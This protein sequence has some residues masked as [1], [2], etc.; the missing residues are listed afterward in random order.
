MCSS[1]VW[2]CHLLCGK[3]PAFRETNNFIGFLFLAAG[4]E[5]LSLSAQ[6]AAKPRF[7]HTFCP[8]RSVD[9]VR[10]VTKAKAKPADHDKRTRPPPSRPCGTFGTSSVSAGKSDR[11]G[12]TL[13]QQAL[14]GDSAAHAFDDVFDYG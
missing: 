14:D 7:F 12:R 2:L 9:E 10:A 13:T 11:K 5:R 6:Q 4:P 3:P 8:L 1:V